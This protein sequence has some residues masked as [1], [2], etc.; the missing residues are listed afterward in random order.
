MDE[1]LEFVRTHSPC[2]S[3]LQAIAILD[4]I[5]NALQ[6]KQFEYARH[7]MNWLTGT[8]CGDSCNGCKYAEN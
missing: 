2:S 5:Q 7:L 8:R 4:Q 3:E 6:H 1:F